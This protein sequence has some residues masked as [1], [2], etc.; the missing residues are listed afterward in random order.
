MC[1]SIQIKATILRSAYNCLQNVL[2][3][4]NVNLN[5]RTAIIDVT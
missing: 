4:S 5:T 2:N 1:V 3:Q